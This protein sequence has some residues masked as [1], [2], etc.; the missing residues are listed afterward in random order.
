M[1]IVEMDFGINFNQNKTTPVIEFASNNAFLASIIV[2]V[3]K[4]Y[5]L[6]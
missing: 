2:K 3:K 6:V 5:V 1:Y 4:P